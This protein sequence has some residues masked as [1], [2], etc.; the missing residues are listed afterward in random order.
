MATLAHARF[1]FD[2]LAA[3][4]NG[5]ELPAYT[6]ED[7]DDE[8]PLFITW[9]MA[10]SGAGS[11]SRLRG[12]IGSFSALPLS[13]GLQEYALISALKD[14]RFS[15][16]TLGELSRLD[17]GV[18][19][20]TDFEDVADPFDWELGEHGIYIHFEDPVTLP[21]LPPIVDSPASSSSTNSGNASVSDGHTGH[22]LK[23][24]LATL[25][26]AAKRKWS[27][28]K[29]AKTLSAT[30]LPDVPSAQGWDREETLDSAIRKAGYTGKITDAVRQSVRVTRYRSSKATLKHAEWKA[31]EAS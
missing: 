18:S 16:I 15:P 22:S 20:L 21:A 6:A 23:S 9:N 11:S 30:Y 3:H 17:V 10:R 14:R 8:Y 2:T 4:L 1:C 25:S 5:D 13:S 19:L 26:G 27:A 29:G 24:R 28:G 7:A 31:G 12:C